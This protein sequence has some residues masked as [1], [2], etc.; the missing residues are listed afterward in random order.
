MTNEQPPIMGPVN[1]DTGEDN[2]PYDE[3]RYY[4][5]EH[6]LRPSKP[7]EPRVVSLGLA[8]RE[9]SHD[10]P[11]PL[12]SGTREMKVT[13]NLIRGNPTLEAQ[14]QAYKYEATDHLDFDKKDPNIKKVD[15]GGMLSGFL[16]KLTSEDPRA[17]D[18]LRMQ[19]IEEAAKDSFYAGESAAE[20]K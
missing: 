11:D 12:I 9:T 7:E 15:R 18:K 10:L 19:S 3:A 14:Y 1:E 5:D 13:R 8:D 4:G 6:A 17:V 16:R 20:K 2:H